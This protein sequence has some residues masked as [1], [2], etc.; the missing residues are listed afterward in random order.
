MLPIPYFIAIVIG[1]AIVY[2]IWSLVRHLKTQKELR[3]RKMKSLQLNGYSYGYIANALGV[4]VDEVKEA[5][6]KKG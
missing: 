4:T 5:M 2:L 1:C 3:E 6:N